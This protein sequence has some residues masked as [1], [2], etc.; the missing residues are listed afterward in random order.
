MSEDADEKKLPETSN[1][2]RLL[3]WPIHTYQP[4]QVGR[5]YIAMIGELPFVFR[6]TSPMRAAMSAESWRKEQY[7]R[8]TGPGKKKH[9][10]AAVAIRKKL[11]AG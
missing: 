8:L 5:E 6:G 10:A 7:D 3:E 4:L 9:D 2:H 1:E 11:G